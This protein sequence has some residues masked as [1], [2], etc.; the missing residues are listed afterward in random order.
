[1]P[2]VEKWRYE[3]MNEFVERE[4]FI[5]SLRV[6]SAELKDFNFL[7]EAFT[8]SVFPWCRQR[9]QIDMSVLWVVPGSGG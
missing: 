4:A 5:D 8:A 6:K 7:F 9:P 2:L 3:N 1:M